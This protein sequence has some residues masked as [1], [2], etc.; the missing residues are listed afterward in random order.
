MKRILFFGSLV[1]LMASV[2]MIAPSALFNWNKSTHDFGK[3][4]QGKPVT[5]E[6]S[7]KN[8]GE[9]PLVINHAQGSCGCTGVDYPKAAIM[10]GQS[11]TIKATFNAASPGAFNKTVSV[12]SNAEGG[13]QTLYIKGEVTKEG[14]SAQ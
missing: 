9:L 2:A 6:F 7:F 5:A 14:A 12:E 10:P 3:I 11:G 13:I 4:P 1:L 8:K